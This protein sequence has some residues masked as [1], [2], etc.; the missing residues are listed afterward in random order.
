VNI[1]PQEQ[2][3]EGAAEVEEV[4]EVEEAAAKK[5]KAPKGR[6]KGSRQKMVPAIKSSGRTLTGR[7]ADLQ[8]AW[9]R[10]RT[11]SGCSSR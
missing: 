7:L 5:P 1:A 2:I 10:A 9:R 8:S 4:E 11:C 6:K 3:E